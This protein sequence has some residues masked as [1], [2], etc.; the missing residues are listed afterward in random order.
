MIEYTIF[1]RL[2]TIFDNQNVCLL[3][4]NIMEQCLV[5]ILLDQDDRAN[6][7][8]SFVFLLDHMIGDQPFK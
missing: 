7:V 8:R 1:A 6:F 2:K 4:K 3:G 5:K